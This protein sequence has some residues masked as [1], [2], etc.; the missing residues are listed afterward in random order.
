M[1]AVSSA[2]VSASWIRRPFA[3]HVAA[4]P[5]RRSLSSST[6]DRGG[7]FL[8]CC[9]TSDNTSYV[10]PP[11]R[12]CPER[13]PV[14]HALLALSREEAEQD[15]VQEVGDRLRVV[16]AAAEALGDLREVARGLLGDFGPRNCGR[17]LTGEV[18]TSRM[19]CRA[20]E[21]SSPS[22]IVEG[23][24]LHHRAQAREVA[25]PWIS[26]RSRFGL[27]GCRLAEH[28]A[29]VDEVLLGGGLLR[30]W[31]RRATS[32]RTCPA[33]GW[34]PSSRAPLPHCSPAAYGRECTHRCARRGWSR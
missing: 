7:R 13:T 17:K 10:S 18:K 30:W 22:Q 33:P 21:G 27:V 28:P 24:H 16:A 2:P 1:S 19:A 29:Q 9:S 6:D 26:I 23:D 12:P 8:P 15:P 14:G 31:S 34:A 4:R 3:D 32:P 20:S 5:R 11:V 25:L